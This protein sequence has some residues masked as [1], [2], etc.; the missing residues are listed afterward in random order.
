VLDQQR[1]DL[2]LVCYAPAAL[3]PPALAGGIQFCR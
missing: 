2:L 1:H 3:T